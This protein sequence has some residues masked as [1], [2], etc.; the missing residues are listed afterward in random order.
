MLNKTKE[1]L[2][3]TKNFQQIMGLITSKNKISYCL[4]PSFTGHVGN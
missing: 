3:S 1:N 2:W 4:W